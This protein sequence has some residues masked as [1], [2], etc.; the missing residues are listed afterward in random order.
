[1]VKELQEDRRLTRLAE[2][3][4]STLVPMLAKSVR[5]PAWRLSDDVPLRLVHRRLPNADIFFI[6]HRGLLDNYKDMTDLLWA[7]KMDSGAVVHQLV[8][9]TRP[10]ETAVTFRIKGRRPEFWWAESGRIEPAPWQETPEGVSVTVKLDP[11]ASVFVVFRDVASD[12]RQTTSDKRQATGSEQA[13]EGP[14]D[15]RFP[16]GWKTPEKVTLTSLKSWTEMED[17]EVRHFNGIA[18]YST[19]FTVADNAREGKKVDLDLGEVRLN[20]QRVGIAWQAPYRVDITN[21]LH[22]GEN[23]LEVRVTTTWHNR[24]VRDA[25]LPK[26]ERVSR[27]YPESR[28]TRFKGRSLIESGLLGPVQLILGP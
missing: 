18:T 16:A 14:W 15:L 17:I 19:T 27:M 5:P 24:L 8:A 23:R 26:V 2:H 21:V 13:I 20:G 12:K 3:N 10:I 9:E 4:W 25:A 7:R 28:Y 6:T 11:Y 22:S 1:V